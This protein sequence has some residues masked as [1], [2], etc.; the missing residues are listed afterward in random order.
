M[1]MIR[2]IIRPEKTDDVLKALIEEGFPSVTK[3][4]VYGRGKQM[5]IKIGEVFYDELP[6]EMLIIV[7]EDEN[8]E[9]IVKI[10]TENAKTGS[11]NFGDG[12][13]FVTSIEKAYTI[14]SMS[15]GL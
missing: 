15:E 12:R 14:S 2:A 10:I 1:K 7:T 6:K 4:E 5:G 11:G 8:E 3:A 13:I 9:A